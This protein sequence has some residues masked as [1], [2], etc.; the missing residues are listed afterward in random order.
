MTLQ[1]AID[2]PVASGKTAVG[3]ALARRLGARFLDT[4]TMY[5]AVAYVTIRREVALDDD[6]ALAA[7]AEGLDISLALDDGEQSLIVDGVDVT[8]FLRTSE[9][10]SRVSRVS[11]VS[12]VR[13]ALVAQ[14]RTVAGDGSAGIVM[15]GR[16][17]GTVV[18]PNA[19]VKVYLEASLAVRARRRLDELRRKG[20]RRDPDQL[21]E[22]I[23]L[24]DKIDSERSD[25][26]LRPAVDSVRVD[27]DGLRI[28]QVVG[29]I[30]ELIEQL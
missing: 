27:T 10:E 6:A 5:R 2:G 12:G 29:R 18:L 30:Q 14:Q 25:S 17:I 20:D 22:A 4:G 7:L 11:E 13:R 21:A 24:R 23:A 3:R 19:P 28:D 16:D 9:V 8:E 1:V 26:P 15:V